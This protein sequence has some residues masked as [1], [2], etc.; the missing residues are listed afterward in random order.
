MQQ[1]E[2]S[3]ASKEHASAEEQFLDAE[4]FENFESAAPNT[5][6]HLDEM[7]QNFF[8]RA[9]E[10]HEQLTDEE[11][12]ILHLNDPLGED[13]EVDQSHL[14]EDLLL[15]ATQPLFEGST[16]SRLQFSIILMSLC[17]LFSISHHCLD[18]ILT[19]LKNDVLPAGN[20]CPKNS[21]E[22]KTTLMKLG[23][24]HEVIHCCE[25]GKTLYWKENSQLDS[26]SKCH[27]SRY[28]QGSNSIP[29]RVLSTFQ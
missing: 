28:I 19:F 17:T 29:I 25:C 9:D 5:N 12:S 10:I 22:M 6:V 1:T 15:Q 11:D 16:T 24:S 20:S 3:S 7:A 18:E 27:K 4:D 23:L 13:E 8:G 26:C 21:Y 14:V 2:D